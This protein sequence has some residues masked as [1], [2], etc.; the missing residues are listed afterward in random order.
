MTPDFEFD[1]LGF[2]VAFDACGY[3]HVFLVSFY[4]LHTQTQTS[5]GLEALRGSKR[6]GPTGS[7]LAPTN[8]DELL[9]VADLARHSERGIGIGIER[10]WLLNADDCGLEA[11]EIL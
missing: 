2:A 1:L 7:I 5:S 9:D 10:S 3:T 4:F 8:L 11:R 6:G